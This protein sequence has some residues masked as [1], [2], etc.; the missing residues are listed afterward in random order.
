MMPRSTFHIYSLVLICTL[1]LAGALVTGPAQVAL[2]L[3]AIAA[4]V[5][6]L[7]AGLAD[8]LTERDKRQA[9]RGKRA[10]RAPS[11]SH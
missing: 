8:W 2:F 4:L 5:A 10:R 3:A 7:I 9:Y 6:F 11:S 1:G